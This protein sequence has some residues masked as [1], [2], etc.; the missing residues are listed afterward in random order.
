MD[1]LIY[2][3]D[4]NIRLLGAENLYFMRVPEFVVMNTRT[5]GHCPRTIRTRTQQRPGAFAF[6]RGTHLF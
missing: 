1:K 5:S 6:T 3:M 2:L 4:R